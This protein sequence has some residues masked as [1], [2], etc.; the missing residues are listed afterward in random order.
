[1]KATVDNEKGYFEPSSLY[2]LHKQLLASAASDWDDWHPIWPNW[3]NSTRAEEFQERAQELL[4]SE[5][6]ASRLFVLKD[7]RICRLV[8]FWE[9]VFKA[10]DITP[11]Y[12]LTLRN[13]LEV[14]ASLEA[15][16]G[17][18]AEHSL[19]VWLCHQLQAES[20]TRGKPRSFTS[21]EQIL[22]NWSRVAEKIQSDLGTLLPR[23]NIN[24]A[25]EIDKFLSNRL[26]HQI[27][28]ASKI[29]DNPLIS[30]WVKES[31]EI[32]LRWSLAG[33]DPADH[34]SL[35]RIS[36]AL[37]HSIKTFAPIV[38]RANDL[39]RQ[40]RTLYRENEQAAIKHSE[41]V[42]SLKQ[43]YEEQATDL[44]A[45]RDALKAKLQEARQTAEE[46]NTA[47]ATLEEQAQSLTDQLAQTQSELRQRRHEFE[48]T[49]KNLQDEIKTLS[50][51][52]QSYVDLTETLREQNQSLQSSHAQ[53]VE[54]KIE[55]SSSEG[56][57]K[58]SA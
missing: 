20:D 46:Q 26:R 55:A 13:P 43:L 30:D 48:Q 27:A 12:V 18:H 4:A 24:A 22:E 16:D 45:E 36:A 35:D 5:F 23:L 42:A 32:F 34:A 54:Q 10:A 38:T 2:E 41:D 7:P 49:E 31:Y 17:M 33:E 47:Q 44:I 3:L 40:V 51:E 21:Y 37:N 39:S 9:R 6:G 8:P 57:T 25:P 19:L 53:Q 15:R 28:P 58:A 14:A 11:R 50:N 52:R 29:L 56:R 1:M